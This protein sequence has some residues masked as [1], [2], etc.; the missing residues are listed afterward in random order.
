MVYY[1]GFTLQPHQSDSK[2]QGQG[3]KKSKEAED[4]TGTKGIGTS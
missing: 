2:L 4:E 1:L 3:G